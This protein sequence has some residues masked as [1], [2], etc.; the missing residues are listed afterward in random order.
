MGQKARVDL[1]LDCANPATLVDFW[2]D[3]L[4]YREYYVDRSFAVLVPKEGTSPPLVLQGVPE[5]KAGKNRMHLDIVVDDIEPE[6]E[7]LAALG[8]TRLDTGVQSFG[9]T[10]WVRMLDPEQNEFCVCTGVEW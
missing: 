5:P 7:R 6:V 10:Q 4:G 3:A 2:R 1:V 9:E 8:A